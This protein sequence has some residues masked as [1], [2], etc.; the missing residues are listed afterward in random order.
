MYLIPSDNTQWTV[1]LYKNNT[2][3]I[4]VLFFFCLFFCDLACSVQHNLKFYSICT[5]A[6]C[7]FSFISEQH[8]T[9]FNGSVTFHVVAHPQ[10]PL[11]ASVVT[12]AINSHAFTCIL[13]SFFKLMGQ[14]GKKTVFLLQ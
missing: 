11:I 12:I 4:M 14:K 7:N 10:V 9:H 8:G 2:H 5:A 3:K 13:D 1:L 6:I